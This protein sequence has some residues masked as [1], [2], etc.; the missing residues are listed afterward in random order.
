MNSCDPSYLSAT[1]NSPIDNND[2]RPRQDLLVTRFG[3]VK[4][5]EM[6]RTINQDCNRTHTKFS[7]FSDV[8]LEIDLLDGSF[9]HQSFLPTC[10]PDVLREKSSK[11]H[12]Q[13]INC[14]LEQAP[15]YPWKN[16]WQTNIYPQCHTQT[17][18]FDCF[19]FVRLCQSLIV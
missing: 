8:L 15:C 13:F 1:C 7:L 18:T 12:E 5:S 17:I 9:Y 19:V 2:W 6:F 16:Y 10:I 14:L 4:Y 11:R 3:E